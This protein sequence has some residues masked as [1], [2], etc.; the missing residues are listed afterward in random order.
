MA[1][2]FKRGTLKVPIMTLTP[3][4][5]ERQNSSKRLTAPHSA[6]EKLGEM[7]DRAQAESVSLAESA[8]HDVDTH[9]GGTAKFI[10]E[11]NCAPLGLGKTRRDVG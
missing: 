3:I 5:E 8:N 10:Q 7:W 4:W 11:A 9:L 6:L 1:V 2:S